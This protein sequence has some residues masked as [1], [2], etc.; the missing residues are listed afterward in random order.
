MH[1]H[2]IMKERELQIYIDWSSSCHFLGQLWSKQGPRGVLVLQKS[3]DLRYLDGPPVQSGDYRWP[4]STGSKDGETIPSK[5]TYAAT[6]LPQALEPANFH[7]HLFFSTLSKKKQGETRW[8]GGNLSSSQACILVMT[9]CWRLSIIANNA[10]RFITRGPEHWLKAISCWELGN[11]HKMDDTER[12]VNTAWTM[13]HCGSESLRTPLLLVHL[14]Y[15]YC[16]SY[17]L[18]HPRRTNS[19]FSLI[20][21]KYVHLWTT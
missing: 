1:L 16:L 19:H 12:P 21:S 2:Y 20:L 10:V 13:D 14:S 8:S 11:V 15:L 5:S 3:S 7:F 17:F 18:M 6:W 4:L 9:D